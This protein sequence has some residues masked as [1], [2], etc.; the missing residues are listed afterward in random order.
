[1][2]TLEYHGIVAGIGALK[3]HPYLEAVTIA[4]MKFNARKDSVRDTNAG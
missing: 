1:M 3:G 4:S 2:M